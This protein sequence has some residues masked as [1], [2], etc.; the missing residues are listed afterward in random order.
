MPSFCHD[1]RS[2]SDG[3]HLLSVA[4]P[5]L[6]TRAIIVRETSTGTKLDP[7]DREALRDARCAV[8]HEQRPSVH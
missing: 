5:V 1:D 7:V 6:L 8:D 3:Q 2:V 4:E